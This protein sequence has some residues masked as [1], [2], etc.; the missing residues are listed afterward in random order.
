[1]GDRFNPNTYWQSRVA[2]DATIGVVGHRSLG[3]AYNEFIYKRRVDVLDQVLIKYELSPDRDTILDI[4]CGTGYF[5]RYW[6]SRGFNRYLGLDLSDAIVNRLKGEI[7]E[8][9]FVVADISDQLDA[10]MEHTQFTVITAFDVLYH[11]VDDKRLSVALT[12]IH[13]RLATNGI[14]IVFDQ[15]TKDNY[16]LRNH[17]KFRSEASY[18]KMLK[19]AGLEIVEREKLFCFLIPPLLGRRALDI[20]I[21]GIYKII[22]VCMRAIPLLGRLLGKGMY[23]IDQVLRRRNVQIPNNEVFI[24]R[25]RQVE[26]DTPG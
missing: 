23:E 21:A 5:S 6:Q 15:L 4:G 20:P 16:T 3:T 18:H 13:A 8:Y 24:V 22:G 11:I 10:A 12:N 19:Q 14:F 7:P 2:V 9:K 17:V 1:M 25:H 26:A